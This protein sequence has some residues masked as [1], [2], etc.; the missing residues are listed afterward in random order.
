MTKYVKVSWQDLYK[1]T[2][3]CFIRVGVPV[4]DAE[5][6]ADHLIL[7]NLRGVDSHGVIRIPYYIEGIRKGYVK[8]KV[9]IKIIREGVATALID[10]DNGL[11]IPIAAR[12]ADMA[13]DKARTVGI[14]AVAV[15]N[16]GHVGMLAYYTLRMARNNLIG[17]ATANGPPFV[18]PWG[19]AQRVFGTNP[20]S[21]AFPFNGK[22]IVIDMATSSTASFKLRLAALKGEKIPE[23]IALTRDGKPTTDPREAY[24]G[25]LLPFGGYKGYAV[26]LIVE[27]L[28]AV[29]PGGTLSKHVLLHP[30]TQ[31]GFFTL[32][33]NPTMFRE[34]DEYLGDVRNLINIIKSCPP[35]QGF[36]EVLIPG[37][38]EDRNYETRI[39]D[40][41]PIDIETWKSLIEIARELGIAPPTVVQ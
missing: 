11:G 30:S 25:I 7:A 39:R 35:A 5:I 20:I 29:L 10:G 32:A 22:P 27:M 3:E 8:A 37:E 12:A 19:G 1:F 18:V 15:K 41:I 31:G 9:E 33:I 16:L 28:S 23:G 36:S 14:A 6:I 34:Y 24:E 2:A 4:H 13:V 38:P 17:L 40:G 26:S 21:M